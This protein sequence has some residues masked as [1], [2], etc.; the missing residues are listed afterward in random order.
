M[1]RYTT[2]INTPEQEAMIETAFAE[3]RVGEL[4]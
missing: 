1:T 4:I 3:G 2:S